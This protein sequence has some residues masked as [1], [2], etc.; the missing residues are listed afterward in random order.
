MILPKNYLE[1]LE[2]NQIFNLAE[3]V[4]EENFKHHSNNALPNSFENDINAILDEEMGYIENSKI[5][6]SKNSLGNILGSIRVLKW[7]YIDT[8]PLQKIFSINPLLAVDNIPNDIWHIG[9]FAI[10]KGVRDVNLFKQL[11]VCAIAP[12]CKHI[13]NV[14]F[15]ECD[16]KLLRTLYLLGIK[17]TIIGKSVNYLGSETIPIC[18]T[19][20][21]L[22]DFYT[23]NKVLVPASILYSATQKQDYSLA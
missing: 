23:K 4:V 7:N 14:A 11:M 19:Y 22:I 9:R 21:G 12:V 20:N 1:I 13:D 18:M 16:S 17:A 5:F 2:L 15:A 8:L 3:F 10:R 6:V